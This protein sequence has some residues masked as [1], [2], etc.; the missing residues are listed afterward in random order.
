MADIYNEI[1]ERSKYIPGHYH[2]YL[3]QNKIYP[4]PFNDG[5]IKAFFPDPH[6]TPVFPETKL[7]QLYSDQEKVEMAK[8]IERK[9]NLSKPVLRF[10]KNV[11]SFSHFNAYDYN[12]DNTTINSHI[13]SDNNSDINNEKKKNTK[14]I[15]YFDSTDKHK[16]I[17][18][19]ISKLPNVINSTVDGKK[20]NDIILRWNYLTPDELA[21]NY[22]SCHATRSINIDPLSN[23]DKVTVYIPMAKH[24]KVKGLKFHLKN[25]VKLNIISRNQQ[26]ARSA[27]H[28]EQKDLQEANRKA[29]DSVSLDENY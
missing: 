22:S 20:E 17:N 21:S 16:I 13:N 29:L 2:N 9:Q 12:D 10:K 14:K 18:N 3:G 23:P 15:R 28:K 11:L 19:T 27:F 7:R 25:D 6:D 24:R 4:Q 26:K 1:E 8:E 5:T